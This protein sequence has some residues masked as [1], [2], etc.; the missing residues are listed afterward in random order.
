MTEQEIMDRL[1]DLRLKVKLL[2]MGL[3]NKENIEKTKEY[4]KELQ[5]AKKEIEKLRVELKK[6]KLKNLRGGKV[7]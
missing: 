7:K 2:E 3:R 6:V 5:K 4:K 1:F